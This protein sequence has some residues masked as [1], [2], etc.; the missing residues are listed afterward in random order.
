MT[1]LN[2]WNLSR[3]LFLTVISFGTL[4]IG[5]FSIFIW[6]GPLGQITDAFDRRNRDALILF[7]ETTREDALQGRDSELYRKCKAIFSEGQL[8][9]IKIYNSDGRVLCTFGKTEQPKELLQRDIRFSEN[10]PEYAARIVA[11]FDDQQLNQSVRGVLYAL[12]FMALGI[13]AL[14]IVFGRTISSLVGQP[15]ERLVSSLRTGELKT[16]EKVSRESQSRVQEIQVLYGGVLELVAQLQESQEKLVQQ[17]ASTAVAEM[18]K[19]VNHDIKSPLSALQILTQGLRG[20]D[21]EQGQLLKMVIQRLRGI[22]GVL[23][24]KINSSTILSGAETAAFHLPSLVCEIVDEKKLEFCQLTNC[25]FETIIEK[26]AFPVFAMISPVEFQRA[27]S[28]IINNSVQALDKKEGRITVKLALSNSRLRV[29]VEDTGKGI[30]RSHLN[31]LGQPGASFF[32]IGG[33]GLGLAHATQLMKKAGGQLLIESAEGKGTK[34][35]IE[36]PQTNHP[37]WFCNFLNLKGARRLVVVD[38]DPHFLQ[39]W[40]KYFESFPVSLH[41]FSWP[42]DADNWIQSNPELKDQTFFIWDLQFGTSSFT[43]LDWIQR[44]G[45]EERSILATSQIISNE[46]ED[47]LR[48]MDIKLIPKSFLTYGKG[49][50]QVHCILDDLEVKETTA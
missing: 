47:K 18:A 36:L 2:K 16:V 38:D 19:Q 11:H 40:K 46:L 9:F 41:S 44:L 3:I 29:T 4:L 30:P 1:K 22:V 33:Q 50:E 37:S 35:T 28:N 21:E 17:A 24:S 23:D 48:K 32:K 20:L 49:L 25:V 45:L 14:S 27:L 34:V 12:I 15:V 7:T 39:L 42:E 26:N 10:S 43:G 31:K 13:I 5:L 6:K 8:D